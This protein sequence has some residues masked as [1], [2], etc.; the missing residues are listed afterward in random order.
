MK[1]QENVVKFLSEKNETATYQ[2][3]LENAVNNS[4]A[5]GQPV[6][7]R[8]LKIQLSKLKRDKKVFC[9]K[10]SWLWSTDE[11]KV[12]AETTSKPENWNWFKTVSK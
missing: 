12:S 1:L 4:W 3:L 8:G 5:N 6:K 10:D 11:T 7:E 9:S 2:E